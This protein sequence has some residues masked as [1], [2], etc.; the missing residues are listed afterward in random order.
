MAPP[1][2]STP[3]IALKLVGTRDTVMRAAPDFPPVVMSVSRKLEPVFAGD[4]VE[5]ASTVRTVFILI[6]FILSIQFRMNV[7]RAA[8][9]E[10]AHI[11]A[12]AP[13]PSLRTRSC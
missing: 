8:E 12:S 1:E 13:A 10:Q 3:E 7:Y 6:P 4:G 9:R 11:N 5:A 2:R